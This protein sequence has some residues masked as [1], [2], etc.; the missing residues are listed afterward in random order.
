MTLGKTHAASEIE[1]QLRV[2]KRRVYA[3]KAVRGA[4]FAPAAI[5]EIRAAG[6]ALGSAGCETQ[7]IK[8]P[9]PAF[10]ALPTASGQLQLV[11]RPCCQCAASHYSESSSQYNLQ[12]QILA[13]DFPLIP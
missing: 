12:T 13:D 4:R 3:A 11:C 9:P 6:G 2:Y 5:F 8:T 10:T 1:E 7:A